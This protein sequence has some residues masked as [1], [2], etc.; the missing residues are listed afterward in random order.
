MATPGRPWN[1]NN[2]N[3]FNMQDKNLFAAQISSCIIKVVKQTHSLPLHQAIFPHGDYAKWFAA[4]NN[5]AADYG[6]DP[7]EFMKGRIN[8]QNVGMMMDNSRETRGCTKFCGANILS[9]VPQLNIVGTKKHCAAAA[10]DFAADIVEQVTKLL[11]ATRHASIEWA[12]ALPSNH[13]ESKKQIH[14]NQSLKTAASTLK[15][16]L[17]TGPAWPGTPQASPS[18]ALVFFCLLEATW[19]TVAVV[20]VQSRKPTTANLALSDIELS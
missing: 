6:R 3:S 5:P 13:A 18:P 11:Q 1:P 4:N 20:N 10:S 12:K 9:G 15:A 7:K 17:F 19:Y 8:A 2:T 16:F 14:I